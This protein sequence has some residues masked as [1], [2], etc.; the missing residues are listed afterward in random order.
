MIKKEIIKKNAT[1]TSALENRISSQKNQTINLN[2]WIFEKLNLETNN[3]VLELCCGTGAQ[4]RYF[5]HKVKSGSLVCVDINQKSILK[6]KSS[7]DSNN[8]R[9][10]V[11]EIDDTYNYIK[12]NYDLIFSA[13]GFYYSK[14]PESLHEKLKTYLNDNGRFVIVG[15]VLGNNAQLYS[16]IRKIGCEIPNEVINGSENFM[17][18]FFKIFL[19]EYSEVKMIR[20]IN[21]VSYDSHQKLLEYWRNTTFYSTGHDKEFLNASKKYFQNDIVINKSIAYLEGSL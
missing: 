20:S 16:I 6:V 8:V 21:H 5:A 19:K 9:F 3:D 4:T 12:N 13:Y 1:I 10:I 11:S 7:I 14:N 18:K 15:P 17:I 2:D